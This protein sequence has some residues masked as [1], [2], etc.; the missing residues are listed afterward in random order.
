M[1]R[2]RKIPASKILLI[3]GE[4]YRGVYRLEEGHLL[5]DY[6]AY[7]Q[8][9]AVLREYSRVMLA[10]ARSLLSEYRED[11]EKVTR[12]AKRWLASHRKGRGL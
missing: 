2:K 10:D 9:P 3:E 1:S 7:D 4:Q 11:R 8:L 6:H 12:R 5:G